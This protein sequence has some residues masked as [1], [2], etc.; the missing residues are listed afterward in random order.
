VLAKLKTLVTALIIR[1][2][3]DLIP[4]LKGE[5]VVRSLMIDLYVKVIGP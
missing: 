2:E 1:E 4:L 5:K 3:N